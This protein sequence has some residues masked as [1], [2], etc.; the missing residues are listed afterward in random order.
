MMSTQTPD[1]ASSHAAPSPGDTVEVV[2]EACEAT[3]VFHT[4]EHLVRAVDNVNLKLRAGTLVLVAGASGSGKTTLLNLLG[5][6]DKPTTGEIRY[7]GADLAS[8]SRRAITQW[9]RTEVSIIFQA[10]ALLPGLSVRENVDIPLRI[11]GSAPDEIDD[12]VD[13]YLRLVGLAA[14]ADHRVFELS[15][16]EQQRVAVARALAKRPSAVL[17]DE[18]TGELDRKTG[19]KVLAL[20]RRLCNEE[21]TTMCVT[22][23]DPAAREFADEIYQLRDGTVVSQESRNA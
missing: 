9:R 2:Y 21:G 19:V 10:F 6:L 22:S 11:A 12:R 7:R 5:G 17:A 23:H 1:D 14:R 15:G 16:G 13:Y 20:L 18:P 4:G 8:F 3:R